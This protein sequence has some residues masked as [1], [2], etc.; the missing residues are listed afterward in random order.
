MKIFLKVTVAHRV[1][2]SEEIPTLHFK[3]GRQRRGIIFLNHWYLVLI[4][5]VFKYYSDAFSIPYRKIKS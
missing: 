5:L 1:A 4:K 2:A 3:N